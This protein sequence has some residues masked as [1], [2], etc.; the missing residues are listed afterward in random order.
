MTWRLDEIC[1]NSQ[2]GGGS[3]CNLFDG[4][5]TLFLRDQDRNGDPEAG[6]DIIRKTVDIIQ[7]IMD[8]SNLVQ[9]V[10]GIVALRFIDGYDDTVDEGRFNT[11]PQLTWLLI[12]AGGVLLMGG[13]TGAMCIKKTEDSRGEEE[14]NDAMTDDSDHSLITCR[15]G[16][17]TQLSD[18]GSLKENSSMVA[19]SSSEAAKNNS[20][21]ILTFDC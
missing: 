2:E 3:K 12:A 18:T 10:E 17:V 1:D 7:T 5:L 15:A 8:G 11:R 14:S 13:F 20:D 16:N 4:R 21:S 19:E 9:A 6:N